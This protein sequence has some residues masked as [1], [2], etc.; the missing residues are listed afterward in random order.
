MRTTT[1]GTPNHHGPREAHRRRS[2]SAAHA[3]E[4]AMAQDPTPTDTALVCEACGWQVPAPLFELA[5]AVDCPGHSAG[6]FLEFAHCCACVQDRCACGGAVT[7]E[8]LAA[9]L[10][11]FGDA[12]TPPRLVDWWD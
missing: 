3:K 8:D 9:L 10:A 5:L 1:S 6:D 2:G 7:V 11:A 12:P 4:T